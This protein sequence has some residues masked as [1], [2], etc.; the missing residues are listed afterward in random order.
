WMSLR[1]IAFATACA[2]V[3][4]SMAVRSQKKPALTRPTHSLGRRYSEREHS[5]PFL[6]PAFSRYADPRVCLL[7]LRALRR[8]RGLGIRGQGGLHSGR[9][10][11]TLPKRACSV[12]ASI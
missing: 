7:R 1:C 5:H 4:C 10:L 6:V 2:A 9:L 11:E 8:M 12:P 3:A